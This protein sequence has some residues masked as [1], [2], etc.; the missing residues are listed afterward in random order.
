MDNHHDL[1][2][3]EEHAPTTHIR[4][5]YQILLL[6]VLIAGVGFAAMR[7]WPHG[8][9]EQAAG[10]AEAK[11][12]A[13]PTPANVAPDLVTA[14]EKEL[15]QLGIETV[16][17]R[18]LETEGETTG[19]V[20]YNEER[21]TPIYP[22]CAGRLQELRANKGDFV[23]AGQTLAVLESP[24]LIQ[25]EN[26]LAGARAAESQA[27]TAEDVARLALL[28]AQSLHEREAISTKD[29]QQAEADYARAKEEQHR[30]RAAV[31]VA[32]SKLELYGKSRD[33]ILKLGDLGRKNAG[34]VDNRVE[35][36][37]P[38]AGTIV[39]RKVGPGQFVKMDIPEPLF[40]I[41]DLS[42]LWVQA[43][44]YESFLANVRVGEPVS[45]TV[46]AYPDRVFRARVSFISPTVDPATRTVHVRCVVQNMGSL[47]KPEMFAKIKLGAA[48]PQSLPAVPASA[49]IA[50]NNASYV[51]VEESRGRFRRR[52]ITPGRNVDGYTTIT[53]GLKAGERVITH[54]TLLL[55]G[56]VGKPPEADT[57]K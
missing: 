29:M 37:A 41:S 49:I 52:A 3:L 54:G 27:S 48:K 57:E 25:A 2:E 1:A 39:E 16:S 46:A 8:K 51:L 14:E 15:E 47:L 22:S 11:T 10:T 19:K 5:L 35:L 9:D 36:R 43:D 34:E 20:G 33:E 4:P 31:R 12:K 23:K 40:M 50:Q 56:M 6:L 24:D 13:S 53:E 18:T 21:V 17:L 32:E 26:D 44:V 28:R 45:I 42:N 38:F 7:F 30:T 55:N